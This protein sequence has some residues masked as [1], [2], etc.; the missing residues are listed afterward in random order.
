MFHVARFF[1]MAVKTFVQRIFLFTFYP[2]DGKAGGRGTK[3]EEGEKVISF[4]TSFLPF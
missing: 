3:V 2:P 4:Q 1:F